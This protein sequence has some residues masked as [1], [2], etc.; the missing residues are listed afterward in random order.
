MSFTFSISW[1]T[2]PL[3]HRAKLS[4]YL[5]LHPLSYYTIVTA[6]EPFI[7]ISSKQ[8][9]RLLVSQ[10]SNLNKDQ[11]VLIA[12]KLVS[13]RMIANFL[14]MGLD[15]IVIIRKRQKENFAFLLDLC[16]QGRKLPSTLLPQDHQQPQQK[17]HQSRSSNND[18]SNNME[19]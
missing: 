4:T 1:S 7:Q 19:R 10:F 6:A 18:I 16:R 3:I 2:L 12:E 13:R 9:T 15:E 14:S 17:Q 8:R 11:A 5:T